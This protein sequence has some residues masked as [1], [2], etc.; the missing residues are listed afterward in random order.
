M[1]ALRHRILFA[2]GL[3]PALMHGCTTVTDLPATLPAQPDA[4]SV[5]MPEATFPDAPASD[6]AADPGP[7]ET[8][9][10]VAV[11]P[12][13]V[14]EN[15]P[16]LLRGHV[17]VMTLS[18]WYPDHEVRLLGQ[19]QATGATTL[20][21][22]GWTNAAGVADLRAFIPEDATEGRWRLLVDD[23]AP[24]PVG[25]YIVGAAT[26][27]Y[28]AFVELYPGVSDEAFTAQQLWRACVP[29][30]L[31]DGCPAAADFHPWQAAE[32]VSWVL[33]R[34]MVAGQQLS[35]CGQETVF[36]ESCCYLVSTW[37]AG[38]PQP[39]QVCGPE[40]LPPSGWTWGDDD[41]AG[42]PFRVGG[43]A[44]VA[45]TMQRA[46][47][48]AEVACAA[49]PADLVQPLIDG[50]KRM[51]QAEHASVASFARFTLEMMALG[52]PADLVTQA[53]AAQADEVRHAALCFGVASRFSGTAIGPGPLAIDGALGASHD[54]RAIL[55]AAVIEG[56]IQETISA[57]QVAHAAMLAADP[58]LAAALRE[59]A[60]DEARHAELSWAFVRW[61]LTEHPELRP[62]A[63]LAFDA[64]HARS[65]GPAHDRLT[66]WGL[67]SA[68]AEDAVAAKVRAEVI[69]PCAT[70]LLGPL[71]CV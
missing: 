13:L 18:G 35:L 50:W 40:V 14:L 67:P 15:D 22:T 70:A 41:V 47:W 51:G 29:Q 57:A 20:L 38:A 58:A 17:S 53:I 33:D 19:A 63:A 2:M 48:T 54:L 25:D 31:Y 32:I 62:A 59:V 21:A 12:V 6:A 16:G 24:H 39:D 46:G 3:S 36:E 11:H 26:P 45:T 61:A 52:A 27:I 37:A 55:T 65:N 23:A 7:T 4:P 1:D 5:I 34:P 64:P 28:D 56:C 43:R 69:G 71:V 9:G 42:R 68:R 49:P 8:P 66:P 44:R 60:D 30:S 10:P